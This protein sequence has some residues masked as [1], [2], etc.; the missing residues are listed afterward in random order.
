MDEPDPDE[1]DALPEKINSVAK[2]SIPVSL[3]VARDTVDLNRTLAN[4]GFSLLVVFAG[5]IALILATLATLT[6]WALRPMGDAAGQIADIRIGDLTRRIRVLAAPKEVQTV[7][8]GVNGLLDRVHMAFERERAFSANVAHELRTPLAGLRSMMEVSLLSPREATDY[9][10]T[11][12]QCLE[13]NGQTESIVSNLL[14]LARLENGHCPFSG[15]RVVVDELLDEMKAPTHQL[16]ATR[17]VQIHW[18]LSNHLV[19]FTDPRK[20]RSILENLLENAVEHCHG[21]GP[22]EI[23]ANR[24]SGDVAIRIANPS[25]HLSDDQLSRVFDRFWRGDSARCQTGQHSGLGLAICQ[26]LAKALGASLKATQPSPSLFVIELQFPRSE[27]V[28][29]PTEKSG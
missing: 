20:L 22:V 29:P 6:R 26:E 3:V 7:V 27:S 17:G 16:A 24:K 21:A 25:K 19:I 9:R 18:N 11:I 14:S 8:D 12:E 15:E 2:E 5:M 23:S 10:R 28:L 13:T 4:L 1:P